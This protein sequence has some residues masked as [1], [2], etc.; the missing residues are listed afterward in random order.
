MVTNYSETTDN[1]TSTVSLTFN[2][3]N[4]IAVYLN[5]QRNVYDVSGTYQL[6]LAPG[7]GAFILPYTE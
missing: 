4:K 7:E 6:T 1:I 3:A 2:G 5:G